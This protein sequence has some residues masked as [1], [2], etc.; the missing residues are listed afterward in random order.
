M[1]T[2]TPRKKAIKLEQSKKTSIRLC[3]GLKGVGMTQAEL[4]HY[5]R[6]VLVSIG[7]MST[8]DRLK[9]LEVARHLEIKDAQAVAELFKP[10]LN[11]V[12]GG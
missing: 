1:A 12:A 2:I 9:I 4:I 3:G 11:I 5:A 8:D 6:Q 7:E 10:F